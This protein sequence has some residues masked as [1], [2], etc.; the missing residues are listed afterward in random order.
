MEAREE[1]DFSETRVKESLLIS[2]GN[3]QWLTRKGRTSSK[4]QLRG[5]ILNQK[6]KIWEI[7][8]IKSMKTQ[9]LPSI[10]S[11]LLKSC[12]FSKIFD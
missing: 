6:M 10:Q 1:A 9:T 11:Q 8:S 5:I 7:S 12:R 3:F 4:S 2:C